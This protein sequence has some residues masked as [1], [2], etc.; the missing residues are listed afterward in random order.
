MPSD[1]I[2]LSVLVILAVVAP[3]V[4]RAWK[5]SRLVNKLR[6]NAH[7]V[8]SNVVDDADHFA[9]A[10]ADDQ[11]DDTH[12]DKYTYRHQDLEPLTEKIAPIHRFFFERAPEAAGFDIRQRLTQLQRNLCNGEW[13][14]LFGRIERDDL[15]PV[16]QRDPD[17]ARMLTEDRQRSL[18]WDYG[19]LL[20]RYCKLFA[21]GVPALKQD[22]ADADEILDGLVVQIDEL[23]IADW[24]EK[25]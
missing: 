18:S 3:F 13:Q 12:D 24:R 9:A 23:A 19:Q 4:W 22:V 16:Y 8:V 10:L 17:F 20:E 14:R 25:V 11:Y 1:L 2:F 21:H 5:K 15:L 6:D 7:Q